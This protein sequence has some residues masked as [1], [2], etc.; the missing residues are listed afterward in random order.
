MPRE[1][2][3]IQRASLT[4]QIIMRRIAIDCMGEV[5]ERLAQCATT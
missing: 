1:G 2:R 4:K 5:V 3:L